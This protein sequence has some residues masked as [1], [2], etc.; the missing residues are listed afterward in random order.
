MR[1]LSC[2]HTHLFEMMC[3]LY[4]SR[5]KLFNYK[6]EHIVKP[7]VLHLNKEFLFFCV[8]ATEVLWCH[9]WRWEWCY[10]LRWQ[11]CS[12][13]VWRQQ[14]CSGVMSGGASGA[15]VSCVAVVVVSSV[16]AAAV[17]GC[18]VWRRSW[19]SG[20]VWRQQWCS[21]VMCMLR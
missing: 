11:W 15:V 2:K 21:D 5:Y 17:Q 6:Y 18:H 19:C 7:I 8:A 10:V 14:W 13:H 4:F 12:G 16:A 3:H 20:H 9:V 1:I